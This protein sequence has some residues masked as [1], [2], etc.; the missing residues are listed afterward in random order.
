MVIGP[1]KSLWRLGQDNETD[2]HRQIWN[3]KLAQSTLNHL[4]GTEKNTQS[5]FSEFSIWDANSLLNKTGAIYIKTNY[6]VLFCSSIALSNQAILISP[7]TLMITHHPHLC[8]TGNELCVIKRL[9]PQKLITTTYN[10]FW[11]Q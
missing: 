11:K 1:F 8:P 4:L 7:G 9:V 2:I 6:D 10:L 5:V 3:T